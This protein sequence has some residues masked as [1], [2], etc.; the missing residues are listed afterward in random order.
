MSASSPT[1]SPE[2]LGH[3]SV[4]AA[5][6]WAAKNADDHGMVPAVLR[7]MAARGLAEPVDGGRRWIATPEGQRAY[8]ARGRGRRA[9]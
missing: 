8:R 7:E 3:L 9:G 6:H 5:S 4:L 2:H 1:V